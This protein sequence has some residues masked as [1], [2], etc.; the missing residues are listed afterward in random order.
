MNVPDA[1]SLI[2]L[3]R[4]HADFNKP[5]KPQLEDLFVT[6]PF[7]EGTVYL[8]KSWKGR[9]VSFIQFPWQKSVSAIKTERCI[10]KAIALLPKEDTEKV[11]QGLEG[12]R[13][14]QLFRECPFSPEVF[15]MEQMPVLPFAESTCIEQIKKTQTENIK[16]EK[17][18]AQSLSLLR[19]VSVNSDVKIDFSLFEALFNLE[20]KQKLPSILDYLKKFLTKHPEYASPQVEQKI[21]ALTEGLEEET[22]MSK[23]FFKN[24]KPLPS[25]IRIKRMHEISIEMVNKVQSLDAKQK[26]KK[27][28][29]FS[30]GH[31]SPS[32]SSFFAKLHL[33]PE[34][35]L[36]Q[37]PEPIKKFIQEG[38]LPDPE[39][40][41]T[42]L[43]EACLK[44]VQKEF[45]DIHL[46]EIFGSSLNDL[47]IKDFNYMFDNP[48]REMPLLLAFFLPDIFE[49]YA[50]SILQKGGFSLV[51]HYFDA[52]IVKFALQW[53]A[54]NGKEI[55]NKD[56]RPEFLKKK[57]EEL[58]D[59]I[60]QLIDENFQ[61][62]TDE[63]IAHLKNVQTVLPPEI[64]E[65][66]DLDSLFSSG[67]V[68]L[69]FEKQ[70]DE[71]F[72]LAI[73]TLGNGLNYH[74]RHYRTGKPYAV[75]R[76]SKITKE[77]IN[78]DFFYSLLQ[79]HFEPLWDPKASS[80]AS[81]IYLGPIA[82]LKG[83]PSSNRSEDHQ[84]DDNSSAAEWRIVCTQLLKPFDEKNN[85]IFEMHLEALV[86][87]CQPYLTGPDRT[88]VIPNEKWDKI[89][90]L[91]EK[92]L[93]VLEA[94][95]IPIKKIKKCEKKVS[96][97]DATIAE[98]KN[99]I[100]AFKKTNFKKLADKKED[101]LDFASND[102][103]K[104]GFQSLCEDAG[105]NEQS[106]SSI[107]DI[108]TWLLGDEG[109]Q[110]FDSFILPYKDLIPKFPAS[111]DAAPEVSS[112]EK[113]KVNN[114]SEPSG[115]PGSYF[116]IYL[117][118]AATMIR[119][120]QA[121]LGF[122]QY[123]LGHFLK[124]PF[125]LSMLPKIIPASVW[126][127]YNKVMLAVKFQLARLGVHILWNYILDESQR[128]KVSAFWDRMQEKIKQTRSHIERKTAISYRLEMATDIPDITT[129]K[130]Q[131]L[132]FEPDKIRGQFTKGELKPSPYHLP[133]FPLYRK[134]IKPTS[135][136]ELN[137]ALE[138]ILKE[139]RELP[140]AEAKAPFLVHHILRLDS[141]LFSSSIWEKIENPADYIETI[142][143]LGLMLMETQLEAPKKPSGDQS[144]FAN[145]NN[146]EFFIAM[147]QLQA[148]LFCLARK[149]PDA[150]LEN[151][152]VNATPLLGLYQSTG[153]IIDDPFL[154][155]KI[156][157]LCL[158]LMPDLDPD[159][160]MSQEKLQRYASDK[161]FHYSR[162]KSEDIIT[163]HRKGKLRHISTAELAY[164]QKMLSYP[165]VNKKL[166]DL[167]ISE[168]MQ[169]EQKMCILFQE[170]LVFTRPDPIFARAFSLL[171]L[172]TLLCQ[173]ISSAWLRLSLVWGMNNPK[174]IALPCYPRSYSVLSTKKLLGT[175][176]T[177]LDFSGF[178]P[179]QNIASS[180]IEGF[181]PSTKWEFPLQG[182]AQ[183]I[184]NP[185]FCR[186]EVDINIRPSSAPKEIPYK[187]LMRFLLE[188]AGKEPIERIPVF[189]NYI[190]KLRPYNRPP[191]D[192]FNPVFFS[193]GA[194]KQAILQSPQIIKTLGELFQ[195]LI[196]EKRYPLVSYEIIE[197][198]IRIKRYCAY[199]NLSMTR[200][201][202]PDFS[203][204]ILSRLK[205]TRSNQRKKELQ[206]LYA[207]SFDFPDSIKEE[208]QQDKAIIAYL[209]AWFDP[210]IDETKKVINNPLDDTAFIEF[211]PRPPDDFFSR[212]VLKASFFNWASNL[213]DF[214]ISYFGLLYEGVTYEI[215]PNYL[216]PLLDSNSQD[217]L[218][219]IYVAQKKDI[220]QIPE[221]NRNF[222]PTNFLLG[223]T[224]WIPAIKKCL[225]DPTRRHQ[226]LNHLVK[227]KGML[228][229]S[230]DK[231]EDCNDVYKKGP[232][233]I[234]FSKGVIKAENGF[235]S[236]LDMLAS[237]EILNSIIGDDH[238]TLEVIQP[239]HYSTSD[240][241]YEIKLN[242][243]EK[244]LSYE[245]TLFQKHEGI[246]F[247]LVCLKTYA[248]YFEGDHL[249]T[250]GFNEKEPVFLWLEETS[251]EI[252]KI[253]VKSKNDPSKTAVLTYDPENPWMMP[254]QPQRQLVDIPRDQLPEGI[255]FIYRFCPADS[256]T[257]KAYTGHDSIDSFCLRKQKLSFKVKKN[258]S[259]EIA[260][261]N[262]Y[263]GYFIAPIQEHTAL[264]GISS[265][266]LLENSGNKKKTLVAK[267]QWLSC[268][269][270]RVLFLGGPGERFL[271][272]EVGSNI[273]FFDTDKFV[274]LDIVELPNGDAWLQSSD[275][276]ILAYLL[277]LYLS[278]G[279]KA[280][281]EQIFQK[282]IVL[283]NSQKV[284]L[285]T[286][287][288]LSLL[289]YIPINFEGIVPLRRS[290]FS[291]MEQNRLCFPDK[292]TEPIKENGD[293]CPEAA[294]KNTL[295]ATK[296]I[297]I[298]GITLWDLHQYVQEPDHRNLM[299]PTQ[300]LFLFKCAFYHLEKALKTYLPFP[301][302]VFKIIEALG[303]DILIELT[304]LSPGLSK[305]YRELK[306][307]AG[308]KDPLKAQILHFAARVLNS[309]SGIPIPMFGAGFYAP[310]YTGQGYGLRS[311]F[312][313]A[314]CRFRDSKFFNLNAM[315]IWNLHSLMLGWI[316]PFPCVEITKITAAEIKK[317]FPAYY[318]LAR[319]DF[320]FSQRDYPNQ[321]LPTLE[322]LNDLLK[323]K[324]WGED[325]QCQKLISYLEAIMVSPESYPATEVLLKA[326]NTVNVDASKEELEKRYPDWKPFFENLN[327]KKF[328]TYFI[329]QFVDPIYRH[330]ILMYTANPV[331][332][333]FFKKILPPQLM[334]EPNLAK[335][336][337]I[338][339][340]T[341]TQF[342]RNTLVHS[343]QPIQRIMPGA[344]EALNYI[345][346][347]KITKWE[348]TT[349]LGKYMLAFGGMAAVG[350]AS[351][352]VTDEANALSCE[353][354]S[355]LW[356]VNDCL[357]VS[358]NPLKSTLL[359][360]AAAGA[361]NFAI[362]KYFNRPVGLNGI[363][364][365]PAITAPAVIFAGKT[366]HALRYKNPIDALS[367]KRK[368]CALQA[369]ADL[370]SLKTEDGKIDA[371]LDELFAL[372]FTE[373]VPSLKK[374][375]RV[376]EF[377]CKNSDSP[378][379][380][381][382]FERVNASIKAFYAKNN[383]V[384]PTFTLANP[385]ALAD[386]DLRL[387]IF[388]LFFSRHVAEEKKNLLDIFNTP[389]P[390]KN[391]FSREVTW[392]DLFACVQRN[393]L[394]ILSEEIGLSD[395]ILPD[396][397]QA[398]ALID[399]K[400]SRM[401]QM[402][403]LLALTQKLHSLP[404]DPNSQDYCELVEQ[405][406]V[407]LKTRTTFSF[408]HTPP[409][410]TILN[411]HFQAMSG[412]MLWER[413]A[414]N[415][416]K[417]LYDH[418]G[419]LA[420]E[421]APG[422]GKTDYGIPMT[423]THESN[424]G[425]LAIPIA[426]KQLAGDHQPKIAAQ[427]RSI[428]KKISYAQ[429]F[430]REI[431]LEKKNLEALFA[432]MSNATKGGEAIQL[433]KE[434]AQTLRAMFDDRLYAYFH[435]T[436]GKNVEEERCLILF[437]KILHL[438]FS[439]AIAIVDETHETYR[440]RH[441][442]NF[443]V[444]LPKKI[445][446][447]LY[448]IMEAT[449][450]V[451]SHDPD[452]LEP[453]QKNK[454]YKIDP[455]IYKASV[456]LR[457]AQEMSQY[458]RFGIKNPKQQREFVAFVCDE[459]DQIPEWI[460][461][462]KL[463]Y[464]QVSLVKGMLNIL[465]PMNFHNVV[466]VDFMPSQKG[467]GEFARPADGNSHVVEQDSIQSP[468]ET[469]VK[470]M[471]MLFAQ[472]LSVDQFDGLLDTLWRNTY[473]QML[474]K[475]ILY[476]KTK[477]CKKFG[478]ILTENLLISSNRTTSDQFKKAY[479]KLRFDPD[480]CLLYIR[481]CIWKQIRYWDKCIQ[482]TSQDFAFIFHRQI[483]CTG[484]PYND[485]TY[486]PWMKML[487]D[488]TTIGELLH[489]IT[490]KCPED[491]IHILESSTPRQILN[492]I[493]ARF[494]TKGSKFSAII[495]G[496][497]QFTGIPNE[498]VARFIMDFCLLHRKDIE[499]VK[500][501][502]EDANGNE[503]VHCFA[504]GCPNAIPDSVSL[505]P[506][507]CLTYYDQRHGFG[508]DIKQLGD[509]LVTM[510]PNHP[511]YRLQ[512][513]LFR[514]RGLKKQPRLTKIKQTRL[515]S[516]LQQIH[517][518]MTK[519]V[520]RMIMGI[521]QQDSKD[522][523]KPILTDIINYAIR[524]EAAIAEEE[525]YPSTRRKILAFIKRAIHAKMMEISGE[526]FSHWSKIW[527]SFESL[528]VN[529]VEDD[530]SKIFG[531]IKDEVD[532]EEAID[533]SI[534]NAYALIEESPYF[535]KKEKNKVREEI[536]KMTI[537]VM[538]EKVTIWKKDTYSSPITDL[539][540]G[541][542]T[543]QIAENTD[544]QE[545]NEENNLEQDNDKEDQ[546][547]IQNQLQVMNQN[548]G[549]FK[550]RYTEWEWPQITD[551]ASLDWLT[552]SR[553]NYEYLRFGQSTLWGLH[554]KIP[555]PF[556]SVRALLEVAETEALKIAAQYFDERLWMAN[557]FVPRKTLK[558]LD[559]AI[560][561]GSKN[562]F[563]L[564]TVLMHLE[565]E[566]G[567]NYKVIKMGPLS[568]HD[569]AY[570]HQLLPP[571]KDFWAKKG[572]KTVLWD[573][574]SKSVLAGCP[575]DQD[576]LR[577]HEEV[578]LLIGQLKMLDGDTKLKR[579]RKA[580]LK[581]LLTVD[582]EQVENAFNAIFMQRSDLRTKYEGS[583]AEE[584]F[585]DA[586]PNH[587]YEEEI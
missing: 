295:M 104:E 317:N 10:A 225:K 547:E 106:L 267:Q 91:L 581:W 486:S 90:P 226:L 46:N 456:K 453:A 534:E 125:L 463:L 391:L 505:D 532:S 343:G 516:S 378:V 299:T 535:S 147:Y 492:E 467:N 133:P 428:F 406:A 321:P 234:D 195:K 58:T 132:N 188:L 165:E 215:I 189:I 571:H 56:C 459:A 265:F 100:D 218:D 306:A 296:E 473:K 300:E 445:P 98:I 84:I 76:L 580:L 455:Q 78:T 44:K 481:Y 171:K 20:D 92:S 449:A 444:G 67:P 114:R 61:K 178:K 97:V 531:L 507:K 424:K 536:L 326:H 7:S 436:A 389:K 421:E 563:N 240:K 452:F 154:L 231:W 440:H 324:K 441:Q 357:A 462:D 293:P 377:S 54:Q 223:F 222:D 346:T 439:Q 151:F 351:T 37:F 365:Y 264:K 460:K 475:N 380:R 220:N 199:Y 509:G 60:G 166:K 187:Y 435:K 388:Y 361:I 447:D 558:W 533:V 528:F 350:Y 414:E 17:E 310:T 22:E 23:S 87:F 26:Q 559:K 40:L 43:I 412:K 79:T 333:N 268:V 309:P 57:K 41:S 313:Q 348:L 259:G 217:L 363:L 134:G 572:I 327:E 347:K 263:P 177:V 330:F 458:W 173:H 38:Q 258:D 539:M 526:K 279:N 308:L 157:S 200:T 314:C 336:S 379:V 430:R 586:K 577:K 102:S 541:L 25:E 150:N 497:A 297:M 6:S 198:G 582:A 399:L 123:Q 49:P 68:W 254:K 416:R 120:I 567:G 408:E 137:E 192:L 176:Y 429:T 301:K 252:K 495:D 77:R 291:A 307:A 180:F 117:S 369:K 523:P 474:K 228:L 355:S 230:H 529:H 502:K 29:F 247:C 111:T 549:F 410:L 207:I 237:S 55:L 302:S 116:E 80:K 42:Q 167:G 233:T 478:A 285:S 371:F 340:H 236:P 99:A 530:P 401:Q 190:K 95:M 569:T 4:E 66:L 461:K 583:Q 362:A 19:G 262:E 454:L 566:N 209:D 266:L 47:D 11:K 16:K 124:W 136:L 239:G 367:K 175:N 555:C 182:A 383:R 352:L 319:G 94:E 356:P 251:S 375:K 146:L 344:H 578:N 141:P 565:E 349:T 484:T 204:N 393:T 128:K 527:L 376:K 112:K 45:P 206:A 292:K 487:R 540:D 514:I 12:F 174:K 418:Q 162:D 18:K 387:Q 70:K 542:E 275:P 183:I 194:L 466:N 227:K 443:T 525:N 288:P 385:D 493:L 398:M 450:R 315:N 64:I 494:F 72:N 181:R 513:E 451:L 341:M 304:S 246:N 113:T 34:K 93:S 570:W 413:Q 281:V 50:H 395:E 537:P 276:E 5:L 548:E 370:S 354:T 168:N 489:I 21:A 508:A 122:Y 172:Q 506:R 238:S 303:W 521:S 216:Y 499:A 224:Y 81:D 503:Q 75:L 129:K 316:E 415:R 519:D 202:F 587:P 538:Q 196:S 290:L 468:Y 52:P 282:M 142:S 118:I 384:L 323:L 221:I 425:I 208:G 48:S 143:D 205:Y 27:L 203:A 130:P 390:A 448:I 273:R 544:D 286:W 30:F 82:Y 372:A 515:H 139:S 553:P 63:I 241:Q 88:L 158:Y 210:P 138:A 73:Y 244:E 479:E 170:S 422:D 278:Q 115:N 69:E 160:M 329:E 62:I 500:F 155:E 243:D 512:Q 96:Q 334:L 35:V 335:T 496:G 193:A 366:Y 551:P 179:L 83:Q 280:A 400:T 24:G 318:A 85:P 480:I 374:E 517:I 359:G 470:T 212:D 169:E 482:I 560:D 59:L 552:L 36:H 438:L 423:A 338:A 107:R 556:Y 353:A 245:I 407:E 557:N 127:W 153:L 573:V 392:N 89:I 337:E 121:G 524:N 152:Q 419:D 464:Q 269:L 427:L 250:L 564:R 477:C 185:H 368:P 235:L 426:P 434:D 8:R 71:S 277:T 191:S 575:I 149:C 74:P 325:R 585:I 504:R 490:Q 576:L 584:L 9:I 546:Q 28:F 287:E 405:L 437:H 550:F 562:Q 126:E 65:L 242:I 298:A 229:P 3:L 159:A 446:D 131:L 211:R 140:S 31:S 472:G 476:S 518:C 271:M 33:L 328:S 110:L 381:D 289:A 358:N 360:M 103:I 213:S 257:A 332:E 260:E 561:V 320:P 294:S 53:I 270:S 197:A 261:S 305:R 471:L 184:L 417:V 144:V 232:I 274:E 545:I 283:C 311:S 119:L 135:S 420:T 101:P 432:L 465:I 108:F 442:L 255:R 485:G 501:Y 402:E 248:T 39:T 322:K 431:R 554:K 272:D 394:D 397:K 161:L 339:S 491:G 163:A 186:E 396:L 403:R 469:L 498:D 32:I 13:I 214:C 201:A 2:A 284:P 249:G 1:I 342:A 382:R 15:T 579:E 14:S 345:K 253:L 520:Q 511:L 105:I 256:I 488:P 433:T 51:S 145:R 568:L 574:Y 409:D 364:P 411:L 457:A 373:K 219:P 312:F 522:I 164:L 331:L 109:T 483:S 148:M 86:Q 543:T 156:Q 404:V 510:G 386:V